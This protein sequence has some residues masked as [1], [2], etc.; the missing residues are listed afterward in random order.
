MCR[1]S[2]LPLQIKRNQ[3]RYNNVSETKILVGPRILII[4]SFPVILR[5]NPELY[6]VKESTRY[7]HR[8][9]PTYVTGNFL[10]CPDRH[11]N[12]G[13][14]E[15]QLAVGDN[16]PLRWATRRAL[17]RPLGHQGR[18]ENVYR[19]AW[20]IKHQHTNNGLSCTIAINFACCLSPTRRMVNL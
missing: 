15:R 12:A 16:A 5:L 1:L 14:C 20:Y 7:N 19:F 4:I 8:R 11:L 3:C 17:I 18:P 2:S 6:L 10:A 9:N 13:S